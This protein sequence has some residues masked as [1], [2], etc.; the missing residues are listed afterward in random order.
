MGASETICATLATLRQNKLIH[1]KIN[2]S[3]AKS[4]CLPQCRLI[5]RKVE[6]SWRNV[7]SSGAIQGYPRQIN[8]IQART[9]SSVA[10]QGYLTEINLIHGKTKSSA[11]K[12]SD[13]AA[14]STCL[15]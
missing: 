10:K 14:K 13:F 5:R 2:L 12:S 6:S 9:N 7:D 4:A 3:A 15:P 8:L 1:G 11:A